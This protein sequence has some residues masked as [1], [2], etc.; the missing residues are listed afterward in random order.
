MATSARAIFQAHVDGLFP[1]SLPIDAQW[2]FLSG[3]GAVMSQVV[4]A[5]GD[6]TI[7]VPA[8]TQLIIMIPPPDSVFTKTWKGAGGDAGVGFQR[9]SPMIFPYASGT[10]IIGSAG[11]ETKATTFF[12]ITSV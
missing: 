5:N 9:Q 10:L 12:F 2:A 4:M 6:N 1:E 8:G 7:A 11:A 3:V